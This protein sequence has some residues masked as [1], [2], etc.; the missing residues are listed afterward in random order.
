M[1]WNVPTKSKTGEASRCWNG[2]IVHLI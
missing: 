2:L 1:Q